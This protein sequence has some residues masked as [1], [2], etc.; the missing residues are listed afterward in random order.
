V[1]DPKKLYLTLEFEGV[2]YSAP[3][4]GFDIDGHS[5]TAKD[6]EETLRDRARDV[7]DGLVSLHKHMGRS[8]IIN[9]Q[10]FSEKRRRD[11]RRAGGPA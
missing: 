1:K 3:I 7:G 5:F 11:K 9:V 2:T 8:F 6:F 4:D 10:D